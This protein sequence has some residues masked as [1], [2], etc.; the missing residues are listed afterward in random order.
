MKTPDDP[1]QPVDLHALHHSHD[2]VASA[3]TSVVQSYYIAYTFL[4][5]MLRLPYLRF[6]Q[7]Y[8]SHPIMPASKI[9]SVPGSGTVPK[10]SVPVGSLKD[11]SSP[12]AT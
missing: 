1:R 4:Y 9:A 3:V 11:H 12:P 5:V 7:M 6:R 10:V 2:S 8:A